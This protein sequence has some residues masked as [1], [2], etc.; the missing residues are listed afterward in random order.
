MGVMRP[1]RGAKLFLFVDLVVVSYN[2]TVP[3]YMCFVKGGYSYVPVHTGTVPG[4]VVS[5]LSTFIRVSCTIVLVL[6]QPVVHHIA[7]ILD[8]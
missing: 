5:T 1:T 6:W 4:Y 3:V 2:S 7:C 8:M